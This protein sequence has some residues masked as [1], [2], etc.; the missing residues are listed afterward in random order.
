MARLPV[1]NL[2]L[3][4][5]ANRRATAILTVLTVA[6]SVMLFLG[7][8]KV[9]HG[10]R[11]SFEN[12][13]SGVDLIVGARSSPV[14]LLLYSVFHIGDATN[15]I[16]WE[17]YETVASAPGVA[18][19]VPISLGDSHRGHR[20]IGSTPDLFEHYQYGGGRH[21]EFASGQPF[22]DLFG[23]VI[24][25]AVAR[26]QG[27][28]T[29]DEII[30]AHGMGAVGFIEHDS[31]PFTVVGVLAPTGTPLDQ[32]VMVTLEAIEAIH[33]GGATG[34]GATVSADELRAMDLTP[35]QLTAFFVG[36]DSPV[37]ALRLQ[38]AIN[39]YPEEP[40]Q[41]VIPGV[42]LAQLWSI[43]GVA[44]RTLAAVAAFVVLTGLV[45]I[46]TAILTS[47]NERR[48][49]MAIL[50][51]LGARPGHVFVLLVAEAALVA[52]AGAV[53]GA[54]ATYGALNALAPLLEARFG[55]LLPGLAP[56]LYDLTIVGAVTG[57]AALLGLFPAWRAYRNSLA[58]GMTIKL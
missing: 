52:L 14:N 30:V 5:I 37:A 13:I 16:T 21:L 32:S 18:W 10:A 20:V 24:G 31:N 27:Y 15:N 45:S 46:L 2:A 7:V 58:D 44:E 8:E 42:A 19:T 9:R 11:E 6:I 4:S 23:A 29:G 33:L 3:R 39:T 41:A 1:L 43:V 22:S 25:A 17:S 54:I 12:T 34:S 55:I 57:A 56:G 28:Q 36:L 50:R 48:R 49:E 35:D 38:R 53:L 26:E 51:A 47:L 40:L